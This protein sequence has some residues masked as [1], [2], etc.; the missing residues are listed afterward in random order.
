MAQLSDQ[1]STGGE[2]TALSVKQP[3]RDTSVSQTLN[4]LSNIL[5][6]VSQNVAASRQAQ[7]Q[8]DANVQVVSYLDEQ[9]SV[10]NALERGD[11]NLSQA[12][13]KLRENFR[14]TIASNPDS[15]DDILSAHSTFMAQRGL[16]K[17]VEDKQAIEQ[18]TER[19]ATLS[20]WLTGN[21]SPSQRDEAIDA[22]LQFKRA[23]AELAADTARLNNES[24][25]VGLDTAKLSLKQKERAEKSR[26]TLGKINDAYFYK[27]RKDQKGVLDRLAAGEID[28]RQAT[29]ELN[30]QYQTIQQLVGSIGADAG[31]D[32]LS[33]I[34]RSYKTVL[35]DS[36]RV[37]SGEL[38]KTV[39]NNR[40]EKQIAIQKTFMISGDPELVRL[41][42]LDQLLPN[43]NL[44]TIPA[45][46]R[47]AGE[48]LS[49]NSTDEGEPANLVGKNQKAEKEQYSKVIS[50]NLRTLNSGDY[51]P[52]AKKQL[53]T[54]IKNILKGFSA[55]G[56]SANSP[57]GLNTVVNLLASPEF[58]TYA[59][60]NGGVIAEVAP[61][62][63]EVFQQQ[64]EG[65]AKEAIKSEYEGR[66]LQITP[67]VFGLGAEWASFDTLIKPEFSGG[68]VR[69]VPVSPEVTRGM[70]Y[71]NRTKFEEE[72]RRINKDVAPV[73]NKL[74]RVGAHLQGTTDYKQ[75]Y[76][77]QIASVFGSPEYPDLQPLTPQQTQQATPRGLPK[78]GDVVG[79]YR[80]KGGDPRDKNNWEVVSGG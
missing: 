39:Y 11:I 62:A 33:N 20:G 13:S 16:G 34:T 40:V 44:A 42:A 54:N 75:V 76:E 67:G 65:P 50:E 48:I 22:Y 4:S 70:G 51:T 57:E 27:Y 36:L 77:T 2:G 47:K 68:G 37:A 38:D 60:A 72:V 49:D 56:A 12:R 43:S 74:V 71:L 31:G 25:R 52:E 66:K 21:E 35:D 9:A 61:E 7:A 73:I 17:V 6:S 79:D 46:S 29:D 80:F 45:V 24:A 55:Y 28:E 78:S 63:R 8:R 26:T 53:D 69:F 14:R 41:A 1:L 15:Y 18:A 32:Y 58:G 19:E 5:G 3:V 30:T 64:Y 23:N 59:V 10:A